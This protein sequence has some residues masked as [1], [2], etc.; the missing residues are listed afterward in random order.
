MKLIIM[1]AVTQIFLPTNI[2]YLYPIQEEKKCDRL[3]LIIQMGA[4]SCNL[5]VSVQECFL[6]SERLLQF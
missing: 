4:K 1:S 3:D 6:K 5:C 2:Y